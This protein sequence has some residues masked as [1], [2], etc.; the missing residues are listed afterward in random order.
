MKKLF[1]ILATATFICSH[2]A[3]CNDLGSADEQ[4]RDVFD[5]LS[6]DVVADRAD[7]ER[8]NSNRDASPP[9]DATAAA[10]D[11]P[12]VDVDVLAE[13][14]VDDPQNLP[15]DPTEDP[16]QESSYYEFPAWNVPAPSSE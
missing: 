11:V 2:L 7:A 6:Q 5:T 9:E 3:A 15:S 1:V 16:D 14:D 10:E 13:A 12:G 4:S 8:D